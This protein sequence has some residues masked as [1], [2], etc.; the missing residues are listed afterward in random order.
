MKVKLILTFFTLFSCQGLVAKDYLVVS[1]KNSEIKSI[2][3]ETVKDIYLGSK[4]FWS[5]GSRIQ[6]IHLPIEDKAFDTFLMNIVEM[7][8]NQFLSYWRRKLFSGRA[9]P[10]KQIQKVQ[11][12]LKFVEENPDSV[13]VLPSRP[14]LN[15]KSLVIIELD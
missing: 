15:S 2:D 5:N 4:L 6:P 12:I 3:R 8:T 10:P 9:H 11:D 7:D 13:A 14:K 1:K